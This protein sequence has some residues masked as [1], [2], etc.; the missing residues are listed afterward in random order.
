VKLSFAFARSASSLGFVRFHLRELRLIGAGVDLVQRLT[1]LDLAAFGEKALQDD[2][3]GL[4]TH[5][6][7]HHRRCAPRQL[8]RAHHRLRIH[9]DHPHLRRLGQVARRFSV[10]PGR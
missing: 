8:G 1:F 4:R 2:A 10:T 5:I 3:A 6:E 9:R 7:G